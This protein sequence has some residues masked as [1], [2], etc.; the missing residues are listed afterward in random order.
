MTGTVVGFDCDIS[1]EEISEGLLVRQGDHA[2]IARS[3]QMTASV[4]ALIEKAIACGLGCMIR[5]DH[6]RRN[7]RWPNMRGTVYLAFSPTPDLQWSLAIDTFRQARGDYGFAVFNGK[8]REQF[9]SAG[10]PFVFEGRNRTAGH[11][12]VQRNDVFAALDV[13]EC[14][15]HSV[16]AMKRSPASGEGFTTE[17]V[18]QRQIMENWDQTP[19]AD[20]YDIVQDEFPVDGGLTSRRIDI[21]ARGRVTGDWLVIELKRA[22]AKIA[23]VNQLESYLLALGQRDD[24]AY[25]RIDGVL[26]AER[27]PM[28]VKTAAINA[29]ISTYEVSWPATVVAV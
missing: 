15:D 9:L 23:A 17:Y 28:A 7:A 18:I 21:L 14:C 13:L 5:E 11:L 4:A 26:V 19:F 29:L 25:G 27:I 6:P 16:L 2:Y 12:V 8:Y 1:I 3:W 10:I 22:E 20:R 24:F